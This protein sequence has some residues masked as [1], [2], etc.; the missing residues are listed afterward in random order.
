MDDDRTPWRLLDL[1][2]SLPADSYA[3]AVLVALTDAWDELP[4]GWRES[5]GGVGG[6][7]AGLL[8]RCA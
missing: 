1:A 8:V 6:Q 5:L 3:R 2:W 7:E 4:D